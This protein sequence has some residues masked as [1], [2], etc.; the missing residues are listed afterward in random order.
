MLE[1]TLQ[2]KL[3]MAFLNQ[4]VQVPLVKQVTE[5]FRLKLLIPFL[6]ISF[7]THVDISSNLMKVENKC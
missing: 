3:S 4:A 2:K 6:S 1:Q 5:N 7:Q